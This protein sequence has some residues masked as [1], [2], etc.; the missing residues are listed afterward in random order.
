MCID[1][2]I[3]NMNS[4]VIRFTTTTKNQLIKTFEYIMMIFQ[5]NTYHICK[6]GEKDARNRDQEMS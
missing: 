5:I 2:I 3:L 1:F 4:T 6:K